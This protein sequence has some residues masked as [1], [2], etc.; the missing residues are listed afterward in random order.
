MSKPDYPVTPAIRFLRDRKVDF[1]PCLYPYVEHGGTAHSAQ[2]LGVPEHK[3]VKTI[4]LQ[5]E[6]KKGMIVL[7]HGDK[8][9]S[10]RNLARELGMKHIEPADPKQANKWT[11]FLVGGTSPFGIK[12]EL[13]VYVERTI[14]DLDVIYINGGK[15]GFLVAVSPQALKTL[16]PQDVSVATDT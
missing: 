4:V 5:N 16:N 7:M 2:C 12:T 9:I 11:G 1:E 10:T 3:V 15:R 8:H 13:P 14:W 6:Q